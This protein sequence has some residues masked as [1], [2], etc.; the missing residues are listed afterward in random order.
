MSAQ[1]SLSNAG[2]LIGQIAK[3][4]ATLLA[5]IFLISGN[6]LFVLNQPKHSLKRYLPSASDLLKRFH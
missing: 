4:N 6:E 1:Y 5:I 2:T 3:C